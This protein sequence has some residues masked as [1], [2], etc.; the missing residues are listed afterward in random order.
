MAKAEAPSR[1]R[2]APLLFVGVFSVPLAWHTFD[3]VREELSNPE[4]HAGKDPVEEIADLN[5]VSADDAKLLAEMATR[6]T[7]IDKT[8]LRT[9][10]PFDP[11]GTRPA[12]NLEAVTPTNRFMPMKDSMPQLKQS[13]DTLTRF[14]DIY[15]YEVSEKDELDQLKQFKEE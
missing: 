5:A 7:V 4:K 12:P 8:F 2:M 1:G 11:I 13:R 9:L 14:M 10:L 15:E 3:V 6:Q